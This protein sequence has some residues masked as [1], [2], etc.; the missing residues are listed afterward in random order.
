MTKPTVSVV[1]SVF[2]GDRFLRE[3]IDSILNQ[4]FGGFEFVIIDDG[5]N[6]S[7][8]SIL[9]DYQGRDVRT[10]VYHQ[11]HKGLIESLNRG[12]RLAQGKYI[13]RMDADDVASRDRLMVQ[14]DFMEAHPQVG[15]LG[16]AVEWIN[17]EG[18]PLGIYRN[19]AED[20]QIRAE[21]LYRCAFWH[22]TV[23]LREHVFRCTGGY[24]T[25]AVDAEDYDLW[26]R[27]ADHFQLANLEDIVLKYRI[28]PQQVSMR[29]RT[30]QTL[31]ILA[32]QR[33]AALRQKGQEDVF[34]SAEIITPEL[35]AELGVEESTYERA[36]VSDSRRWIRQMNL[37]GET[38]VAL[39]TAV[40]LLR[41]NWT[42]VEEWQIADLRLTIAGLHWKRGEYSQCI[43]SA[44][45]AARMRPK[46]L[47]RPLRPWLQK[48][49]LIQAD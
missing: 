29:K 3:A 7:S 47:G 24:R 33:S 43:R 15:V 12:C 17:A 13:A 16:G 8:A 40:E 1:M 44:V 5:S 28:H 31:G 45:Q 30:Q 26:L 46:V 18:R 32:A 38:S 35:L 23:M 34:D 20:R 9:D 4:S 11:P 2:N 41:G 25:A 36:L 10:K 6:D 27:I 22:P 49:G 42:H 14:I 19:P 21:L 48:L 39:N 37:A